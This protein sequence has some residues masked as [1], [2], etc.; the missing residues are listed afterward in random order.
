MA[1]ARS[2]RILRKV[3]FGERINFLDAIREN[4]M[5]PPPG[6]PSP[7]ALSSLKRFESLFLNSVIGGTPA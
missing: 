2:G 6:P 4:Q 7:V 3:S 5:N 1:L